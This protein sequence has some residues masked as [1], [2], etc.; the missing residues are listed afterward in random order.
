MWRHQAN[1]AF[2]IL[3]MALIVPLAVG[4]YTQLKTTVI[5]DE[6]FPDTPL[7]YYEADD[8]IVI[9][10]RDSY[11]LPQGQRDVTIKAWVDNDSDTPILLT[12]CPEPPSVV[13]EIAR[14]D[15]WHDGPSIGLICPAIYSSETVEMPAGASLEFEMSL[16]EPGLYR[17]RLLI[18]DDTSQPE[19]IAY[20]NEFVVR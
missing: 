14:G 20:S 1:R 5:T 9:T 16:R 19:A 15:V 3:S 13:A 18:G 17:L 2:R 6:P 7:D 11:R 12:G 10:D 8:L 4:C